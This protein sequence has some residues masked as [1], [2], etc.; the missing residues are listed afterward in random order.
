[1]AFLE[2]PVVGEDDVPE[3]APGSFVGSAGARTRILDVFANTSWRRHTL[4]VETEVL[5]ERE[6]K[7]VPT[8]VVKDADGEVVHKKNFKGNLLWQFTV[9]IRSD[10]VGSA[11][12]LP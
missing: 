5:S 3:G 4:T 9:A 12:S 10:P 2:R 8:V 1:M 7:A 11:Y 6:Q